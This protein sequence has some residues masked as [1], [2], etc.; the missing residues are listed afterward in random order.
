MGSLTPHRSWAHDEI[1]FAFPDA[2]FDHVY[3]IQVIF[4][5]AKDMGKT[6]KEVHRILKPGGKFA[7]AEWVS[8]DK[9][10]PKNPHHA[11]LMKKLKPLIGAIGTRSVGQCVQALEE[12]GFEVLRNENINVGGCQ[13]PLI[14][15]ADRFF[16]RMNRLINFFVAC[17][18]LPRHFKALFDRL[19]KDGQ[20]W[21][22][23]TVLASPP[24]SD[25][26]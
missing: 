7:C 26:S 20:L 23:R 24:W 25:T 10:D 5:Y 4:S 22:K 11:D 1:P 19:T 3:E 14:E 6:L 12:A 8:L 17:K 21:S 13:A 9:Y 18:V 2:S 15:N 16:T